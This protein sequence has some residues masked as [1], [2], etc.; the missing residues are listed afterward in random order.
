MYLLLVS[1]FLPILTFSCLSRAPLAL[2]PPHWSPSHTVLLKLLFLDCR[3]L[4]QE[5]W[6]LTVGPTWV[7]ELPVCSWFVTLTGT[8]SLWASL[9]FSYLYHH[10]FHVA[11][12]SQGKFGRAQCNSLEKDMAPHSSTLAWKIPWTEG[13]G[14]LQSMGSRRVGHDWATSLHFSLSLFTFIPWSRKW[15][16]IPVFLPGE[17]QGQRSLL[18]AVYGVAQSRTRLKWLSSS[19]SA[20]IFWLE[21]VWVCKR[22]IWGI[23]KW[24]EPCKWYFI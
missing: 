16:P 8:S 3:A 21:F 5:S 14:R 18:A 24:N 10:P 2:C 15:Q 7:L 23:T 6:S 19:S 1:I 9:Q 22:L 13:P 20:T 11:V 17:S 4:E 12:R